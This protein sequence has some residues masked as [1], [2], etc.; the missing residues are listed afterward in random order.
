M[1]NKLQLVDVHTRGSTEEAAAGRKRRRGNIGQSEVMAF[2]F[3]A[4]M[5][6]ECADIHG[7]G[8]GHELD[9]EELCA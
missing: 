5:V 2:C 8:V 3:L 6:T 1:E 9:W 7:T 4:A